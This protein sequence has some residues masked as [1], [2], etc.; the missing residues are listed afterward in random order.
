MGYGRS[1]STFLG[2]ALGGHPAV[3]AAGEL[4]NI[5]K[6]RKVHK[7]YCSCGVRSSDCAFWNTVAQHWNDAVGDCAELD[8]PAMM[9]R[10]E[11]ARHGLLHRPPLH[12]R[13]RAWERYA[14][15][16]RS[17]FSAIARTS[18]A[19][20]VVDSSKKPAR[21]LALSQI[22][23]ID[24]R[25]IHLVRDVRGVAL[26]MQKSWRPDPK[27]GIAV[28][29]A[30]LRPSQVTAHWSFVNAQ[31]NRVRR[32]LGARAML[33]R[34]ED[35]IAAPEAALQQISAFTDMDFVP[36]VERLSRGGGIE[37]GHQ[38]A[39]NRLR[40]QS[41]IQLKPDTR[42][43]RELSPLRRYWIRSL[44]AWLAFYYSCRP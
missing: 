41:S 18:S 35:L 43:R 20:T 22:E 31:A 39:G 17:L 21:A 4:S 37:P 44:A 19:E 11:R 1:G 23:D 33:M 3:F 24:L 6:A 15:Y 5:V 13:G 30:P 25:V 32:R 27:K 16:T 26:S 10:F 9:N 8:Y 29:L 38:I 14:N 2:T 40:M 12:Q 34:Y 42:W 28:P 7:E 36:V